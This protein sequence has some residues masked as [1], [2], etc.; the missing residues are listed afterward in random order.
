N[1]DTENVVEI[2]TSFG[3]LLFMMVAVAYLAALVVLEGWPV[4]LYL[5]SRFPSGMVLPGA[6]AGGGTTA[7]DVAGQAAGGVAVDVVPL[8]LGVAGAAAQTVAATVLPLR[9]GMRRVR[10]LDV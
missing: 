1:Y 8:V 3:G 9:A 5:S 2:P 7:S 6:G 4:Y 10:A